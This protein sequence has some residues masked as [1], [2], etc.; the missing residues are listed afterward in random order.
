MKF[1][2]TFLHVDVSSALKIY[3]QE[4]LE[5]VGKF[6]HKESQWHVHYS[7]GRHECKV[8]IDMDCHWGHFKAEAKDTDFYLAI[9]KAAEKLGRQIQKMKEKHQNHKKVERS[10]RAKLK[11]LNP[12]LEY[13][14]S[15]YI[16]KVG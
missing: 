6:L 11:R 5:K 12:M 2:F 9:D 3:S 10:K 15:P 14:N 16:K 8:Q 7:M 1:K 4:E 13:D